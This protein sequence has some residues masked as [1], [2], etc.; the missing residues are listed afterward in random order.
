MATASSM[1]PTTVPTGPGSSMAVPPGKAG[2][3]RDRRWRGASLTS[4]LMF[5]GT[6]IWLIG[7]IL[8]IGV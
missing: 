5:I 3:V 4:V 7:S 2:I 8:F 1:G 6:L